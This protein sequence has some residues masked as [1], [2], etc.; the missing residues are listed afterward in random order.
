VFG[1]FSGNAAL[2]WLVAQR[3]SLNAGGWPGH[4]AEIGSTLAV[5]GG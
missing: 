5:S 2:L 4:S 1:W 3:R